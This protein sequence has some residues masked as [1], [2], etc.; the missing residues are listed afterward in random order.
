[1]GTSL[2]HA[3]LTGEERRPEEE[4]RHDAPQ[5]PDVDRG[6]VIR[7][8]EDELGGAVI[9]RTN[10]GDVGLRADENLRAAEI[11]QLQHVRLAVH[12]Q[13]LRLDVSVTHAAA[14]N[15]RQRSSHLIRVQLHVQPGHALRRLYVLLG[16]PVHRVRYVLQHEV[17][18]HLLLL[19]RAVVAVLQR[20]D[21]GVV[22]DFHDLQ[23]AVFKPL[24][25]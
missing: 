25:L 15:V 22:Q 7:R 5:G 10:V 17:Q 19:V 4:L 6:G 11:A 2:V 9:P 3:A 21:V 23:L 24:V 20:D 1:M 13:V 12:E 18:V 16:Q 8:A 14:V